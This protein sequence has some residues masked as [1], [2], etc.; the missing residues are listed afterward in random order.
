MSRR[1]WARSSFLAATAACVC[2]AGLVAPSAA[3]PLLAPPPRPTI[4]AGLSHSVVIAPDGTPYAVGEDSQGATAQGSPADVAALEPMKGLP[5]G[6]KAV[7]VSAG[8][9]TTL[10]VGSD[11]VPY[12]TGTQGGTELGV[13]VAGTVFTLLPMVGLPPGVKATAV[14]AG[15]Q[16]HLVLGSNGVVYGAGFNHVGQLTGVASPRTTLAPMTGLPAGTKAI[17]IAAGRTHSVVLDDLGR[18]YGTGKADLG[19]ITGSTDRSTLTEFSDMPAGVR[20]TDIAAYEHHTVMLGA[21]GRVYAVGENGDGQL[22]SGDNVTPQR[23]PVRM[24]RSSGAVKVS[25]GAQH[26]VVISGGGLLATGRGLSGQIGGSSSVNVLRPVTAVSTETGPSPIVEADGGGIHTLTLDEDG[27]LR[28]TGGNGE[29]QSVGSVGVDTQRLTPMVGQPTFSIAAPKVSGTPR[30]GV[31]L[32][33]SNGSWWPAASSFT[34]KWERTAGGLVVSNASSYTPVLADA[35]RT[36][37]VRVAASR[38]FALEGSAVAAIRVPL[39]STARPAISGK[40]K[41]KSTLRARVGTWTPR[42]SSYSYRWFRNGKAISRATKSTYK[43]TKSDRGRTIRLEVTAKKS[44]SASGVA[45]SS[46]TK[47]VK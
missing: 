31:P 18:V 7:T 32:K 44:G 24:L 42:A 29:G 30:V 25:A 2:A 43:L 36:L 27:V 9:R 1:T 10:V 6:V 5:A 16:F 12:A 4:S 26:T 35:G 34:H 3:A 46:T 41:V 13:G 22:G 14:A 39:F 19:Q 17:A 47:K 21:D 11:G 33:A 37:Q 28:G 40:L 38:S 8:F 23:S 45:L 20:M 15:R